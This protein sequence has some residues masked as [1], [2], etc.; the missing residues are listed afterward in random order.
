MIKLIRA[1]TLVGLLTA[2]CGPRQIAAQSQSSTAGGEQVIRVSS[3]LV[4]VPVLVTDKAGKPVLDLA[5]GDFRLEKDGQ[6]QRIVRLGEPGSAP[7]E[8]ALLLDVSGSVSEKFLFEQRAAAQFLREVMRPMDTVT[9]FSIGRTPR[10][11][12]ERSTKADDAVAAVMSLEAT[13]EATAFY[14]AVVDAAAYLAKHAEPG[15][16]HVLVAIT[17]G[18]DNHSDRAK[19]DDALA[20]LNRDDCLFYSINPSGSSIDLNVISAKA[21]EHMAELASAIGGAFVVTRHDELPAVFHRIAAELQSQYTLGF[22]FND[23]RPDGRFR[24][25]A[26]SL[27]LRP[28]L[29]VRARLGYY[30]PKGSW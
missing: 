21:Q 20:A 6:T 10:L 22:Y 13:R 9:V 28:D 1:L 7:V 26:V 3:N 17:D 24:Q 25:I 30:G 4:A 14:D 27:P 8:L 12:R 29:R 23:D 11:V 18:E 5:L 16:R 2:L 19:F 15:S